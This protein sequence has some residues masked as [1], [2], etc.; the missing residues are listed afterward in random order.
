MILLPFN[1]DN[2]IKILMMLLKFIECE[3]KVDEN[4]IHNLCFNMSSSFNR[5]GNVSNIVF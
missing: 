3:I 2:D 4:N 5:R 1:D